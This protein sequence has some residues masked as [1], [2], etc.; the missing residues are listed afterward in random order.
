MLSLYSKF[1]DFLRKTDQF[2]EMLDILEHIVDFL[3]KSWISTS[4]LISY[5]KSKIIL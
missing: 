5:L 1:D 4:I 3:G 2:K